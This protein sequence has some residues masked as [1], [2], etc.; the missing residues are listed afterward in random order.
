[1][2][3]NDLRLGS[4]KALLEQAGWTLPDADQLGDTGFVQSV[5]D[6]LC[7]L[8]TRDPLTAAMNRRAFDRQLTSELD[9]VAR[10]GESSLLLMI[11]ID[12][13]K[14]VND[15]HGHLAGDRVIRAVGQSLVECVRPMDTVARYGGEEFAVVLPNCQRAFASVVAE[16]IRARVQATSVELPDGQAISVTVSCGGAFATP[17]LRSLPQDWVARADAQLYAAKAAGRNTVCIESQV[18]TEVSAEEKGLLF[19]LT[20]GE[21]SM[22]EPSAR[23]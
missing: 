6:A 11:D 9:R 15:E 23:D 14:R 10:S 19:G 12:H 4:V 5:I 7:E 16:R 2:K 13:F 3:I 1:M 17:W 21:P 22:M 18:V 8:S 20:S